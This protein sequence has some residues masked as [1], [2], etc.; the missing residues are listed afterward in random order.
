MLR[1]L[2]ARGAV[3]I[4]ELTNAMGHTVNRI[5]EDT[6]R[7]AGW[8]VKHDIG[9]REMQADLDLQVMQVEASDFIFSPSAAVADSLLELGVPG[10][11]ILSTSYG[12]DPARF[13]T[14]TARALPEI[15]GVT[16]LFVGTVCERKG[17]HL[18]LEA[19]SRARIDGRLVLLG[20]ITPRVATHC[21]DLLNR[22]DVV[23]LPF[24]PD[25]G[26]LFRSADI[27]ALPTLEEGSAL[28]TYEAMGVGLPLLT[29]PMGAGCIVR[30]D[31]E[32]L[33]VDPHSG[34]H[35]IAALRRMAGDADLRRA[36][37]EAGRARAL[38]FTWE[39]V[40]ARRYALIRS[41]LS[42]AD[43]ATSAEPGQAQVAPRPL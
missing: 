43:H 6:Y 9:P 29:S 32:G 40:A 2:K 23:C 31:K 13:S 35:L 20:F 39:K 38:E 11:K 16:V 12:W 28:V 5:L 24:N 26:P 42:G 10:R 25:P 36:L 34:E 8:P 27:L 4:L 14:R 33:V 21:A 30:H 7:R 22:P 37:G 41:A 19:W 17:A 3:I 1:A 15:A 18:L